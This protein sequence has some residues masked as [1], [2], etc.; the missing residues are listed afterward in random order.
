MPFEPNPKSLIIVTYLWFRLD[1][2][3][4]HFAQMETEIG[5]PVYY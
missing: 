1:F 5:D 2:G 4:V 3:S